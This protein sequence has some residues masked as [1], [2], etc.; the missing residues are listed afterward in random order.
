VRVGSGDN[1]TIVGSI[2]CISR[3]G[4]RGRRGD[5]GRALGLS[6]GGG[7]GQLLGRVSRHACGRLRLAGHVGEARLA[8]AGAV[9]AVVI[10]MI[11]ASPR[12]GLVQG[13]APSARG[14]AA[15]VAVLGAA[16]DLPAI[17][18]LAEEEHAAAPGATRFSTNLSTDLSPALVHRR[19]TA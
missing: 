19:V 16:V 18:P 1:L 12:A 9:G 15:R 10:A 5:G 14:A 11:V 2:E 7:E 4:R 8:T 3:R 6:D 13:V 17:A